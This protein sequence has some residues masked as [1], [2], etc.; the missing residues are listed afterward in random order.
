MGLLDGLGSS[1]GLGNA[2]S[3]KPDTTI[4]KMDL[5]QEQAANKAAELR[6]KQGDAAEKFLYENSK[7][8][9]IHPALYNETNAAIQDNLLKGA[10]A[11]KSNPNNIGT[12]SLN[13]VQKANAIL[14]D[15]QER[16]KNLQA[17]QDEVLKDHYDRYS[18]DPDTI[19]AAQKIA[20]ARSSKDLPQP[21]ATSIWTNQGGQYAVTPISNGS[22]DDNIKSYFKDKGIGKLYVGF[23]N[24]GQQTVDMEESGIPNAQQR[25]NLRQIAIKNGIPSSQVESDIKSGK[26]LATD[27]IAAHPNSY[28][29]ALLQIRGNKE[30]E[31]KYLKDDKGNWL[32][33]SKDPADIA[34]YKSNL[35]EYIT[36]RADAQ[37]GVKYTTTI[38]ATPKDGDEDVTKKLSNPFTMIGGSIAILPK[39]ANG[40]GYSLPPTN[41]LS[42]KLVPT[43]N[44]RVA[45]EKITGVPTRIDI[46][47][48]HVFIGSGET[49][50]TGDTGNKITSKSSS[51]TRVSIDPST[52]TG[53]TNLSII[54]GHLGGEK[55]YDKWMA[56]IRGAK[57]TPSAAPS[58]AAKDKVKP[59][60][61]M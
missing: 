8:T 3:F 42:D 61:P 55:A 34:K 5:A 56:E 44:G 53:R 27:F 40:K 45:N 12:A 60:K 16:S 58:N 9:G 35:Q 36:N 18:N 51:E 54:K 32:A 6:N 23:Q 15:A 29:K 48:N 26:D 24:N 10:A 2:L 1:T 39:T 28:N 19:A 52:E 22:L 30:L 20:I 14:A 38:K 25:D 59:P 49:N 7:L 21:T 47:G 57:A 31:D 50:T 17:F 11:I 43:D 4:L 46:D 37:S 41:Y 13:Y 33:Q